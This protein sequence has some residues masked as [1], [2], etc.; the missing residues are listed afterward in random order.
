MCSRGAVEHAAAELPPQ[1]GAEAAAQAKGAEPAG[2]GELADPAAEDALP[3]HCEAGARGDL[4]VRALGLVPGRRAV[5]VSYYSCYPEV[6]A[7]AEA[8]AEPERFARQ[9]P[10]C[11]AAVQISYYRQVLAGSLAGDA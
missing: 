2:P 9:G 4:P 11:R 5:R 6:A 8:C 3:R 1:A 10:Q 7:Q